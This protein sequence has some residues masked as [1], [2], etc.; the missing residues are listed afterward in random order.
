MSDYKKSL[1]ELKVL[2]GKSIA[3]YIRDQF[4]VPADPKTPRDD[5]IDQV[6][7]LHGMNN[8]PLQGVELSGREDPPESPVDSP[9]EP[10]AD[11]AP[12]AP[13]SMDDLAKT[14][15][16]AI[17]KA[18]GGLNDAS[19]PDDPLVCAP[20]EKF[21]GKLRVTEVGKFPEALEHTVL[22]DYR[23]ERGGDDHVYFRGPKTATY[24]NGRRLMLGMVVEIH[25]QKGEFSY[26]HVIVN[27]LA[28]SVNRDELVGLPMPHFQ[29]IRDAH[30]ASM[31]YRENTDRNASRL[32]EFIVPSRSYNMSVHGKCLCD[33]KNGE[34]V[35]RLTEVVQ[36]EQSL[37]DIQIHHSGS[38]I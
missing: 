22:E 19:V 31:D 7:R 27:G 34:I 10:I 4:K 1:A 15:V 37:P 11:V 30:E 29:Q 8:I 16:G 5:L 21:E 35:H 20:F 9:D 33:P 13:S 24:P 23:R 18:V 28:F 26:V 6:V 3:A 14:F 12:A 17:G 38:P 36:V 25:P 2:N 32:D